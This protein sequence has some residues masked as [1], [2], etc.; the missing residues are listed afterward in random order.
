[1]KVLCLRK[2]SRGSGH[3]RSVPTS[4]FTTWAAGPAVHRLLWLAKGGPSRCWRSV[5]GTSWG[6]ACCGISSEQKGERETSSVKLESDLN[7]GSSSS[8]SYGGR[9]PTLPTFNI[10]PWRSSTWSWPFLHYGQYLAYYF[11][12]MFLPFSYTLFAI[13]FGAL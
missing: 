8:S 11:V 5:S 10:W 6:R 4:T 2:R 7:H 9:C 13:Q 1:M 3:G 12:L